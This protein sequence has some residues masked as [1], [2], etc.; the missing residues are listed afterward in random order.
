M[1]LTADTLTST[2]DTVLV[3]YRGTSLAGLT[4][5][6]CN[7]DVEGQ[8]S[9]PSKVTF[10]ATAGQTYYFQVAGWRDGAGTAAS[11]NLVFKLASEGPANDSFA[12]AKQ[13]TA[14]THT[15]PVIATGQA[16][17]EAGELLT[18]PGPTGS[19]P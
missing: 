12:A 18:A 2:F 15:E 5:V 3:V 14:L 6:A 8:S 10:A 11:G 13:I 16:T 7:D 19:V 17:E 9:A 1:T 4:R